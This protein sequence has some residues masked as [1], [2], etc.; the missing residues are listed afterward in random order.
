MES[1]VVFTFG[2]AAYPVI[3]ILWRG[4]THWTMELI[5]G[6][7]FLSI[8]HFEKRNSCRTLLYRCL[9]GCLII[10]CVEFITGIIVNRALGWG[11]WDYS[12]MPGNLLGQICITYSALWFLLVIPIIYICRGLRGIFLK[13][14]KQ[15][16]P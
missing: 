4:Y 16:Y 5:G 8:Y 3:E 10:T 9:A 1:V 15:E 6:I 7:C 14:L 11:V 12:D 13:N 2:A